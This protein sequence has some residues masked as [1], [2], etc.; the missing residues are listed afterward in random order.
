M[1]NTESNSS[2]YDDTVNNNG[3]NGNVFSIENEQNDNDGDLSIKNE[4]GDWNILANL[5]SCLAN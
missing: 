3:D 2:S 5:I 1:D 4:N